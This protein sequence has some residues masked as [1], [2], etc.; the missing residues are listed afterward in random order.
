MKDKT[1]FSVLS[2]LTH[3]LTRLVVA[4]AWIVMLFPAVCA[5]VLRL[6]IW[7]GQSVGYEFTSAINLVFASGAIS[8][9]IITAF[10]GYMGR[11]VDLAVTRIA[12]NRRNKI[13]AAHQARVDNDKIEY[14]LSKFKAAPGRGESK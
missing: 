6:W 8:I 1:L 5:I 14:A 7:G 13:L 11:W 4:G 3:P 9:I 12:V 2:F 10:I